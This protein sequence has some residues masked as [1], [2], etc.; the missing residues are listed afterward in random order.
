MR[1]EWKRVVSETAPPHRSKGLLPIYE[2]TAPNGS[3]GVFSSYRD[4]VPLG[5]KDD[6]AY[7]FLANPK[8]DETVAFEFVLN[9]EE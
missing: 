6:G 9:P 4:E 7:E 5:L 2:L 1:A 8:G 3:T